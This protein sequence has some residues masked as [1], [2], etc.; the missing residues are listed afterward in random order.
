MFY[1]ETVGLENVYDSIVKFY[2]SHGKHWQPAPLLKRL[3]EKGKTEFSA[4]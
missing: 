2:Q 3:A 1:A 4:R